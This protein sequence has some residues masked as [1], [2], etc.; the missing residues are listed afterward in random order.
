MEQH[1]LECEQAGNFIE[2]E[3]ARQ[4]VAQLQKIKMKKDYKI[5]K[6]NQ[7]KEKD[8]LASKQKE[9]IAKFNNDLDVKYAELMQKFEKMKR[10]LRQ[11]QNTEMQEFIANM[12]NNP[13]EAKPS[14]EL[15]EAKKLLAY[16][17]KIKE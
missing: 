12:E 13:P 9:E 5:A 6:N 8:E 14:N 15:V 4:R 2:A 17:A 16:F 7:I 11:K 1:Q 3:L 10:E